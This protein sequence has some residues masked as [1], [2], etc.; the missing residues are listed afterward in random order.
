MSFDIVTTPRFTRELK[1]LCKRYASMRKDMDEFE[2][3]ITEN[4][5]QGTDLGNGL[6]KVR[7][8]IASKGK[9]KS[10]GG[11][12]ITLTT[13]LNEDDG[14]LYLLFIYDK[15]ERASVSKAELNQLLA[16]LELFDQA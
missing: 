6:R 15:S 10:G 14:E 8:R 1:R 9:G 12:V 4:P 11:R 16:E 7:L 13:Y 5:L 3:S 2:T